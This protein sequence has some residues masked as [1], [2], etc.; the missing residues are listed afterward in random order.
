MY[1]SRVFTIVANI[2]GLS[3]LW[4][5]PVKFVMDSKWNAGHL[6]EKLQQMF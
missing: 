4:L 5:N 1:F 6:L 2:H 3:K